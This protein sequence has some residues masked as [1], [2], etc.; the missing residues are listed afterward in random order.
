MLSLPTHAKVAVLIDAENVSYRLSPLLE[1]YLSQ[2][3][4]FICK[5]AYG[6]WFHEGLRGW[7]DF[8]CQWHIEPICLLPLVSGKNG[9]DMRLVID[10]MDL[11]HRQL[12]DCLW[13]V[14]S[15]SDFTPLV[16]RLRNENILVVGF[17]ETKAS[18]TYRGACHYFMPMASTQLSSG[19]DIAQTPKDQSKSKATQSAKTPVALSLTSASSAVIQVPPQQSSISQAVA[20]KLSNQNVQQPAQTKSTDSSTKGQK[21]AA[22]KSDAEKPYASELLI[23]ART[24]YF[25]IANGRNWV[26]LD[27]L[28]K[29]LNLTCQSL[30]HIKFKLSAFGYNRLI[31]LL[32]GTNLFEWDAGQQSSTPKHERRI[33]LTRAAFVQQKAA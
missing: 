24:A 13:I 10:A 29:Q 25:E 5:R 30:I 11:V 31:H 20:A 8:L 2:P 19:E 21:A 12:I 3:Y 15:D 6:N 33:R 28:E 7:K 1:V 14:S 27:A 16:Q 32:D 18:S 22:T 17:G 23:I 9:A 4:N 26:M